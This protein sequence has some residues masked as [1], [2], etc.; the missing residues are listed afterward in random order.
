AMLIGT[1]MVSTTSGLL[2]VRQG[3][4][5]PAARAAARL[6]F[7]L[8]AALYATT[9]GLVEAGQTN[10]LSGIIF[11]Y[12][13]G[14]LSWVVASRYRPHWRLFTRV[15]LLLLGAAALA[16]MILYLHDINSWFY[17]WIGDEYAFYS[18]ADGLLHGVSANVFSQ[19]G[20]YGYH[21]EADSVYQ[22]GVMLVLGAHELGWKASSALA[23]VLPVFPIF[24]LAR[25][26]YSRSAAWLAVGIYLPAQLIIAYAH[27]GY[28]NLD[29][30]FPL[31]SALALVVAA[32]QY[33]SP[34]YLF[35]AGVAAGFGWYTFYTARFA[36]ILLALSVLVWRSSWR[37]DAGFI[38]AGFALSLL[39]FVLVNG[40][41]FMSGILGESAITGHAHPIPI[42]S[43]L[44]QNFLR[45]LFAFFYSNQ[46][47]NHWVVGAMFDRASALFLLIGLATLLTRR[48]RRDIF[49][50]LCLT[51][52]VFGT[53][54]TFYNPSIP[55]TRINIALPLAAVVAG[56]GA[57]RL[58]GFVEDMVKLPN[59]GRMGLAIVAV[60]IVAALNF[61]NFYRVV[62]SLVQAT[63]TALE[64]KVILA[65]PRATVLVAPDLASLTLDDP[66]E[67]Y[68]MPPQHVAQAFVW[69]EALPGIET[70]GDR[71]VEILSAGTLP[72]ALPGRRSLVWDSSHLTE[73]RS[74]YS[75][76]WSQAEKRR[77][78]R[79]IKRQES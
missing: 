36:I 46:I 1:A 72:T 31:M 77:V 27:T 6:P 47:D 61:N 7:L 68:D 13:L 59:W 65:H 10:Y 11:L 34:F 3:G 71:P 54:M 41:R 62:P 22:A 45:S 14:F 78:I 39:P 79:W 17:S 23:G 33:R 48:S 24:L 9:L 56:F 26:T 69:T 53:V 66:L 75:K 60:A 64:M 40:T 63:P 35:L 52:L 44:A 58:I 55:T 38:V 19:V 30:L 29:A 73:L 21:P 18:Q 49:V 5:E 67:V 16:G 28:N 51:V 76:R 43:L 2:E 12:A 74:A 20:V 50:V 70:A 25:L 8:G 37:R 42:S 15:D 32:H 57:A 4:A